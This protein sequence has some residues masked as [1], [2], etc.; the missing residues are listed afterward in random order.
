M[1]PEAALEKNRRLPREEPRRVRRHRAA[2][3][4]RVCPTCSSS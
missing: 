3:A 2:L 4:R 1:T